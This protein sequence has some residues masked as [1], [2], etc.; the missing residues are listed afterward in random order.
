MERVGMMLHAIS[1]HGKDYSIE[2]EVF[3]D[4]VSSRRS[5]KSRLTSLICSTN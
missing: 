3:A 5:G 4:G 2:L 1:L